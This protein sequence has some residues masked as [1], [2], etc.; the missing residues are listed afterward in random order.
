MESIVIT[1]PSSTRKYFPYASSEGYDIG[2]YTIEDLYGY[3]VNTYLVDPVTFSDYSGWDDGARSSA[4]NQKGWDCILDYTSEGSIGFYFPELPKRSGGGD[5]GRMYY[6]YGEPD[7]QIIC[8]IWAD[9]FFNNM[10]YSYDENY[11]ACVMSLRTLGGDSWEFTFLIDKTDNYNLKHF[12]FRNINVWSNG[13][14]FGIGY[15]HYDREVQAWNPSRMICNETNLGLD[16]SVKAGFTPL[17]QTTYYN[18]RYFSANIHRSILH[19]NLKNGIS[20]AK[21]LKCYTYNMNPTID[22]YDSYDYYDYTFF[23]EGLE[24]DVSK[25]IELY[26]VRYNLKRYYNHDDFIKLSLRKNSIYEIRYNNKLYKEVR[27]TT[28]KDM[29]KGHISGNISV[30]NCDVSSS[31]VL[32][33]RC[34]RSSDNLFIGDYKVGSTGFYEVPNLDLNEKYDIILIDTSKSIEWQVLSMRDTVPYGLDELPVIYKA[35][36]I[37]NINTVVTS[38]GA[39]ISWDF[40]KQEGTKVDHIVVY[41]SNTEININKIDLYDSDTTHG[42]SMFIP[43]ASLRNYYVFKVVY[44]NTSTLS[45]ILDVHKSDHNIITAFD[46]SP[47]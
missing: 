6:A 19:P 28:K 36:K 41:K 31:N 1:V 29:V 8:K 17:Q 35:D 18:Y 25:Q 32:L 9:N 10:R 34:Y 47:R 39:Y 3:F 33:I 27:Y 38:V 30:T 23:V 24:S 40:A 11:F 37:Q 12:Y 7:Y 5:V 22:R 42:L 26:D 20:G 2:A 43:K 44:G 16:T 45:S 14:T 15:K 21:N 4:L 46:F 13:N